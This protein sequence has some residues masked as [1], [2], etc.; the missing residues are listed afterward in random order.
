MGSKARKVN[1]VICTNGVEPM[2]IGRSVGALK[3]A[4]TRHVGA[5]AIS[6]GN[7]QQGKGKSKP[8]VMEYFAQ[9]STALS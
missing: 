8:W 4:Q 5:N 9:N 7:A 2:P 1:N 3:A 6:P